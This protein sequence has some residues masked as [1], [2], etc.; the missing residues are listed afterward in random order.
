MFSNFASDPEPSRLEPPAISCSLL[1]PACPSGPRL[2][3]RKRW[4]T[5]RSTAAAQNRFASDVQAKAARRPFVADGASPEECFS[6]LRLPR[7]ASTKQSVARYRAA[8]WKFWSL[9]TDGTRLGGREVLMTGLLT[10][11]SG[12]AL[13]TA[14][15]ART[16]AHPV[17]LE[18]PPEIVDSRQ[19]L[20][21][22]TSV[23]ESRFRRAG[24][25]REPP[26]APPNRRK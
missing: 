2:R 22:E 16:L 18:S 12:K 23:S 19:Y 11:E 4:G 14:P 3:C 6:R 7:L 25:R 15:C 17:R 13:W 10:P 21:P 5:R 20:L 26:I 8:G 24:N 1:R 9:A